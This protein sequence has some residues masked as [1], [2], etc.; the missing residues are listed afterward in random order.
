MIRVFT[1]FLAFG[2]V[3][4]NTATASSILVLGPTPADQMPSIVTLGA[5]TGSKDIASA[6]AGSP[7]IARGEPAPDVADETVSAIEA[8]KHRLADM[9]MVIRGGIAG[10]AFSPAAASEKSRVTQEDR[11]C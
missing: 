10:D 7:T 11:C 8:S 9:P 5:P 3:G 4:S 6:A 2:L 1:A